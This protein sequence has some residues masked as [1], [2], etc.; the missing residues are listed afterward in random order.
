MTKTVKTF[1]A[2]WKP[3][4]GVIRVVLVQEEDG[5]RAYFCTD[6]AA[7]V[8]DI[9]EAAAG[10][11][12]IEQ[13]FKDVKEV[14]GRGSSSCVTGGPTSAPT[15]G[16]CGVTR[17]WSGGPGRS[18]SRSCATGATRRGTR[19]NGGHRT[20]TGVRPCSRSC[21]GG[22]FGGVG[23]SGLPAGNSGAGG[24]AAGQGNQRAAPGPAPACW[25]QVVLLA[26]VV[27]EVVQ[28]HLAVLVELNQLVVA[29]AHGP[30][31]LAALVAVVRVVPVQGVP[32]QPAGLP[33]QWQEAHPVDTGAGAGRDAGQVQEG[34]VRNRCWR[35]ARR[36]TL[37]GWTTPGQRTST[38]RGCRPRRGSPSRPAKARWTWP[39]C[40]ALRG[41]TGRRCRR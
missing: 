41:P 26:E 5:W 24:G 1:L 27:L 25:R 2:T 34:R 13:T 22:S 16:A 40:S 28:L 29:P 14:E 8:Q 20:R 39:G 4:G 21:W 9:L 30:A 33:Q 6:P 37:P 17:R 35:P 3:A 32:P 12:A 11:T 10:R 19:R 18:H 23:G 36:T 15:T 38:A 7:S 31:R